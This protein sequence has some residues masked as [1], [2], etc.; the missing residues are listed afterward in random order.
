MACREIPPVRD[1]A[2]AQ[3]VVA[4]DARQGLRD[5]LGVGR[6]HEESGRA[7]DLAERGPVAHH[8]GHAAGGGLEGREAEALVLGQEHRHVG[9]GV[10]L[11]EVGLGGVAEEA[12][13]ALEPEA[14]DER[15][16]VQGRVRPVLA[17]HV[18]C[19]P[20]SATAEERGGLEQGG[21]AAPVEDGADGEQ[22]RAAGAAVRRAGKRWRQVVVGAQGHVGH[23]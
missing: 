7:E 23:S 10:A 15:V 21:E 19:S 11:G 5:R 13:G 18:E 4:E 9:A 12:D 14:V 2:M 20:D 3:V 22:A 17:H 8:Q 6:V 1:E 16:Q